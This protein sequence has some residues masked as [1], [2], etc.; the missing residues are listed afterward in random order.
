MDANQNC[1]NGRHGRER[2][3]DG[4]DGRKKIYQTLALVL[5]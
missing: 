5:R 3:S 1:N 2:V 4:D